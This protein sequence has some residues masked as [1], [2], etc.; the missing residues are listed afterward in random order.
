MHACGYHFNIL[1]NGKQRYTNK[2]EPFIFMMII[3]LIK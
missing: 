2:M 3:I 1:S